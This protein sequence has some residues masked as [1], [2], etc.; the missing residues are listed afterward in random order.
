MH[1]GIEFSDYRIRHTWLSSLVEKALG[2]VKQKPRQK[3]QGRAD[4]RTVVKSGFEP[5]GISI[6]Y[7][8]P[9][10]ADLF[11]VLA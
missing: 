7:Q 1:Q 5:Y 11:L 6:I 4:N 8:N 9:A 2:A 10:Y 3:T